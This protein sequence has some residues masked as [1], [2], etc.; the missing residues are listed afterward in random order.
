MSKN[1][2]EILG[3]SKNASEDEIKK[4]YKKLA[5]KWHPDK[6]PGNIQESEKKFKEISEAY[7][8]LSDPS[9]K[10]IYDNYGEDGLKNQDGPNMNSS[11]DDIFKMFFGGRSPF[12][13]NFEENSNRNVKKTDPKIVNI[14]VTLKEF[15]NGT[16]K[17]ITIKLK[18]I[19]KKCDGYGGLSL[20]TCTECSGRGIIIINRMI[21]PGMIQRIQTVC[22]TCSGSKKICENICPLCNGNKVSI[23]EKDFILVIE[24]GCI[25]DDK[26]IFKDLGDHL[27]NEECGDVIFILKENN[28][29][30]LFKRIGNDLIYNKAITL[31]DSITGV[32]I[33]I[34]NINGENILFNENNIIKP[35]SYSIILNK[36]MPIKDKNGFFGDLYIVYNIIYPNKI[37]TNN[38]KSILKRILPVSS[39]NNYNENNNEKTI[40]NDNFSQKD[41][42]NKYAKN[43]NRNHN[44]DNMHN[45]FS[46]FF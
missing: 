34:I 33:N 12:H 30:T 10:E 24:P 38:E 27:P 43:N 5:I 40:L 32:C 37:L 39:D 6:N 45:I 8:V 31:G 26:K 7:Q 13:Q 15:Y 29:N 28:N 23:N 36:G 46:N 16:K 3:I 44:F 42:E 2:Y 41:I 17:K 21:G 4:S 1:Y 25:H 20:K 22:N 11:P 18:D 14:P 9:K 19:C 35:N